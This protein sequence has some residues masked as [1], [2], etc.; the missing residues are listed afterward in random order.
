M[1]PAFLDRQIQLRGIQSRAQPLRAT[2]VG[3]WNIPS[4]KG[5]TKTIGD[6]LVT[7][8][9]PCFPGSHLLDVLLHSDIR[10]VHQGAHDLHVAVDHQGFVRA[11]RVDSHAAVVEHGVRE[12]RPLPE[13]VAVALKLPR[14]GS[15]WRNGKTGTERRGGEC[16]EAEVGKALGK[17]G[18]SCSSP[19]PKGIFLLPSAVSVPAAQDSRKPSD[20]DDTPGSQIQSIPGCLQFPEMLCWAPWKLLNPLWTSCLRSLFGFYSPP[21]RFGGEC[22]S[23]TL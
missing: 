18:P 2:V 19:L 15:L 6:L 1:Y 23:K 5:P 10:R 4:W 20:M 16:W 9:P 8:S 11:V 14:V 22:S 13:H 21:S 12:L 17:D 3:C 7:P